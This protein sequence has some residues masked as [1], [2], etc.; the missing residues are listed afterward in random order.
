MPDAGRFFRAVIP[1]D[2]VLDFL[3]ILLVSRKTTLILY[4]SLGP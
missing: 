3:A 1:G 4:L 2:L